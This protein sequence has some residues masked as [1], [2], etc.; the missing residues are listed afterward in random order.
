MAN[1]REITPGFFVAA[2]LDEDDLERAAKMGFRSVIIN[3]PDGE[4]GE[5]QPGC[6]EMSKAA[7]ARGLGT[8]Y[9]PVRG[10]QITDSENVEA[11][12]KILEASEAPVLAYCKSGTRSA[13]LWAQVK[14]CELGIEAVLAMCLKAGYDLEILRDELEDILAQEQALN[15][16]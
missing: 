2:Q 16:A 8:H 13:M 5:D 10:F 9:L 4:G 11:F 1:F 6:V 3:R 7:T 14:V 15:A 12:A